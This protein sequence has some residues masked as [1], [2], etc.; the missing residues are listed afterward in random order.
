MWTGWTDSHGLPSILTSV[1]S[2]SIR[3][4]LNLEC[5]LPSHVPI[6]KPFQEAMACGAL[7]T[8]C[9]ETLLGQFVEPL[10]GLWFNNQF[11]V[12]YWGRLSSWNSSTSS[13][14]SNSFPAIK[15]TFQLPIDTSVRKWS[16]GPT[17]R[18]SLATSGLVPGQGDRSP[19]VCSSTLETTNTLWANNFLYLIN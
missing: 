19:P 16:K 11:Y 3:L 15:V 1:K 8:L 13:E 12:L 2:W 6:H 9:W 18:C 7:Y 17:T 14:S 5:T 4:L 10:Q